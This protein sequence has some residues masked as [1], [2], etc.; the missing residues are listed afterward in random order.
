MAE[1]T[2]NSEGGAPYTSFRTLLNTFDRM[3]E[4]GGAPSRVD[5]SYL[6]NMPGGERSAFTRALR[7][8]G[9]I[10]ESL[11][12]TDKLHA[13]VDANENERKALLR[14]LVENVY[15]R[16]LALPHRATQQQLE[17]AF[18]EYG[19]TGS[20]L[21][22]AIS[23]FLAA[24]EF[25]GIDRSPHFRVPPRERRPRGKPLQTPDKPDISPPPAPPK[26]DQFEGLDPF[27]VGLVRRLPPPGDVFTPPM[28]QTWLDT[29]ANV[30]ELIYQ[31]GSDSPEARPKIA[32]EGGGGE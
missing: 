3:K 18:R 5:R 24:T 31:P 22:R 8:L 23:F 29:A 2:T 11:E 21:S 28:R 10:T 27:I 25:V 32:T 26:M 13:L 1:D 16:P 9:L 6:A 4:H 19:I 20:T 7:A 14:P 12:P 17:T 15:A 30:F